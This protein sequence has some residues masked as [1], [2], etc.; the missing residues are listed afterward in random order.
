MQNTSAAL[1][2]LRFYLW[3]SSSNIVCI[4]M[5]G[6]CK[7]RN[8][9]Y[10]QQKQQNPT[11]RPPA[12]QPDKYVTITHI[13]VRYLSSLPVGVRIIQL[14]FANLNSWNLFL[15]CMWNRMWYLHH[16]KNNFQVNLQW[17]VLN[18]SILHN[19]HVKFQ[20]K[21]SDKCRVIHPQ[22]NSSTE[23]PIRQICA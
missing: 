5:T 8:A 14:G 3:F 1:N 4:T 22:Q 15:C 6:M 16:T 11:I 20:E 10:H 19:A 12:L 23:N 17:V 13:S 21:L 2:S 18:S 7:L 9:R